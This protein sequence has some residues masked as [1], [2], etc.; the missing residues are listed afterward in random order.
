MG[1]YDINQRDIEIEGV[2]TQ[3]G[4]PPRKV[5]FAGGINEAENSRA[6]IDD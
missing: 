1:E 2:D 5:L 3:Y 4:S 6:G